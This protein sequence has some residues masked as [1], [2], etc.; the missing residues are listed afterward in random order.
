MNIVIFG[1]RTFRSLVHV[2]S[3]LSNVIKS[4]ASRRIT[5]SRKLGKDHSL[6]IIKSPP[7]QLSLLPLKST[8]LLYTPFVIVNSFVRLSRCGLQVYYWR[9][10]V[11]VKVPVCNLLSIRGRQ[12]VFMLRKKKVIC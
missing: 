9:S 7:V 1:L 8:Q 12:N 5:I 10:S 6:N 4:L 11:H 3:T 2:R